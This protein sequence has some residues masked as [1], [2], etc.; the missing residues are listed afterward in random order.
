MATRKRKTA[1][2]TRTK[3]PARSKRTG[4]FLKK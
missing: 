4:R 3:T 2:K 1:R